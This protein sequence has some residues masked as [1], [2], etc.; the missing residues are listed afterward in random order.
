M[1]T[2]SVA[3][4]LSGVNWVDKIPP[5]KT[6]T[7]DA[8]ITSG[9]NKNNKSTLLGNDEKRR[10]QKVATSSNMRVSAIFDNMSAAS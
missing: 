7:G 5:M 3:S 4:E 1:V 2:G 6:M 10:T 9:C 8:A